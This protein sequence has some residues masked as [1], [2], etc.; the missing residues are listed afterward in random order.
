MLGLL[1]A[2]TLTTSHFIPIA[3]WYGG[4]KVRAPML[5]PDPAAHR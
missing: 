1:L 5:E 3:V 4:G 2:A